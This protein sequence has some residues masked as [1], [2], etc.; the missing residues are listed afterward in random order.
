V[1]EQATSA[2][3][4]QALAQMDE[5]GKAEVV[6]DQGTV[7]AQKMDVSLL[8]PSVS[9]SGVLMVGFT[10]P[11]PSPPP[12]GG[13]APPAITVSVP[14]AFLTSSA[15]AG[16]DVNAVVVAYT[17]EAIQQTL[18]SSLSLDEDGNAIA[19]VQG[20]MSFD[21][22]ADGDSLKINNLDDP[23][24]IAL[25]ASHG[26]G[27]E[28]GYWD[29]D[30]GIWSRNGLTSRVNNV[31]G[32]VVCDTL[33]LTMFGS[34][35]RQVHTVLVCSS[36]DVL[37]TEGLEALGRGDW[38]YY[39]GSIVVYVL[40]IA[41]LALFAVAAKNDYKSGAYS[42]GRKL[43]LTNLDGYDSV[44]QSCCTSLKQIICDQWKQFCLGAR[45]ACHRCRVGYAPISHFLEFVLVIILTI[46]IQTSCASEHW[47]D[48][49]DVRKHT[50]STKRIRDRIA[51]KESEQ[52]VS[53]LEDQS[54]SGIG[55]EMRHSSSHIS[56]EDLH[57]RDAVVQDW[58]EQHMET[59]YK[60]GFSGMGFGRHVYIFFI[61]LQPWSSITQ[62]SIYV[63]STLRVLILSARI[64]GAL[65]LAGLFFG[66]ISGSATSNTSDPQCEDA[67]PM[68]NFGRAVQVG[69]ISSLISGIPLLILIALRNRSIVYVADSDES[70]RQALRHLWLF[71]DSLFWILGSI[72][73]G[74][75]ILFLLSFCANVTLNSHWEWLIAGCFSLFKMAV[76]FPLG[77]AVAL[78]IVASMCMQLP[79]VV[80]KARDKLNLSTPYDDNA[81]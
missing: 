56:T 29:T 55:I 75:C 41:H 31:S 27:Q 17:E 78:A 79:T 21:I 57:G 24:S 15:L 71:Q 37:T 22:Q 66:P 62:D 72:Y 4:S 25:S 67:D 59:Y 23:I 63:P 13:E 14:E 64:F 45:R 30:A 35:A 42:Q 26:A 6:T 28:C 74:V 20:V 46:C 5:T 11:A 40:V 76:L 77:L 48:Q 47:V 70:K 69:I 9:E 61:A 51:R 18:G 52:S 68:E 43:F 53:K 50:K 34:I 58:L 16:K 8:E 7:S 33:H 3:V 54:S 2:A 65:V 73:T 81:G 19:S 36:W 44:R 1:L 38:W 60:D 39:P 10:L 49:R 80:R 32:Q 12:G